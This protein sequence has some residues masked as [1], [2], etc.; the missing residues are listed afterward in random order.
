MA[1]F[2]QAY[3]IKSLT[4]WY[5]K[6]ARPLPWRKTSDPYKIWISEVMLQ[7]TTVATV[8]PYYKKWIKAFPSIKK[9]AR[10]P[11]ERVLRQWQGL[12]YY[13]RARNL[14]RSAKII[15]RQYNACLPQDPEVLKKLP[16]F[17][18]YTTG[19]VLSIAH[20]QRRPIIDANVRRV[21]MRLLAM[22]GFA[23]VKKDEA[24]FEFL[25]EILPQKGVH[26]FN[27]ALMELGAMV[28]RP[29]DPLCSICPVRR[30]CLAYKKGLQNA[31]PAFRK[32]IIHRI[33][34]VT[35]LIEREGELF[36]QQRPL[37]GLLAG[38]WELP[39]GK[40]EAGE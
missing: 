19:A 27:Q 38:L 31:I 7:Q 34:A 5:V 35:A 32:K 21:V 24:I 16:G 36:M 20:D 39:G 4:Q 9:L 18:P 6:N 28:C 40:I 10:A 3:F 15:C 25:D 2:Q 26:I 13:Q 30:S 12:G 14:H 8:I 17:G 23:D 33:E 37:S 22:G 11:L 29:Q 1:T